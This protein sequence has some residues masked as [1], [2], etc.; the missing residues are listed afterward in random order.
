MRPERLQ[1]R[2]S[3]L[4][5]LV[6]TLCIWLVAPLATAVICS[7]MFAQQPEAAPKQP[8][9]KSPHKKLVPGVMIAVDPER[10]QAESFSRHDVVELLAFDPKFDW[11][12]DIPYRHEVWALD[13]QFK[14][15][16]MTWV[17]I[18]Q[19]SGRM[20]K[21]P[22]WYLVYSIT[23][24]GKVLVPVQDADLPYDTVEKKKVYQVKQVDRP[25]RF[26]PEFLLEGR[27]SVVEGDGFNKAYAD[28]IIPVALGVQQ[29]PGP[30]WR[31]EDP[32]RK[33][34][35]SVE[36]SSRE[37]QVGETLWGI[38]TWEDL[39]PKIDRFSI[40]VKGLTNVYRWRDEPGE[41]K[42]GDP[43]GKGRRLAV[44]TLK[45]NQWWPGDEY[46]PDEKEL[47]FGFPGEVD[48]EWVYR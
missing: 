35:N 1:N 19:P 27:E 44:K 2:E 34:Y 40:Y 5:N 48:Y 29:A 12:K 33:F 32:R 42:R 14:P 43:L 30:I 15:L 10:K 38:A 23:N 9:R 20:Q 17:D 11:V 8:V 24:P 31:R 28:R 47:R 46:F 13:F 3:L 22:I 16:R 41:Y 18:P 39:D 36:I 26:I 7:P 45:I 25:V 37:I 4:M 6:K 21:K